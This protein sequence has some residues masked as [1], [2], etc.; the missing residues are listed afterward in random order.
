[1][2]RRFTIVVLVLVLVETGVQA[3]LSKEGEIQNRLIE[4]S[5]QSVHAAQD[6]GM[7]INV[8]VSVD[9]FIDAKKRGIEAWQDYMK[10]Y[11]KEK[12]DKFV[13]DY[14]VVFQNSLVNNPNL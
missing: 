3:G 9:A 2:F 14:M 1:V 10:L 13:K 11:G 4:A 6:L 12:L 7:G 5:L 8:E